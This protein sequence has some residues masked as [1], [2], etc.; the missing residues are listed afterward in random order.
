MDSVQLQQ[1]YLDLTTA[2]V[3][4]ACMQL[5]MAVRHGPVGMRPLWSG[6][7][8]LGRVCP[9]QHYG[10]VDIILE[11]ID[12]AAPGDVLVIDNGGRQDEGCVGDL[13]ALETSRAGLRGMVIWGLHRD[14]AELRTI[15]LPIIS[16]GSLP[17][18]PQR[19][20]TRNDAALLTVRCGDC[21][22]STDDFVLGDDDGVI[23]IAL[24]QAGAVAERAAKIRDAERYKA[25]RMLEGVTL[26][27]QAGSP[28]KKP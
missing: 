26:R 10:S 22:V 20:D 2:H 15:R 23:F 24:N 14:T 28:T 3:A 13:M 25:A 17:V 7:H 9:V 1:H 12:R 6:T 4:D 5:G 8:L 11:A 21:T 19:L 27:S 18:R 16:L